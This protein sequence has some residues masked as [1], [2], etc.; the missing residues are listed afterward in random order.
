MPSH[1]SLET[2]N[3]LKK[4]K[5]ILG[6]RLEEFKTIK[7][8]I[9]I[10]L[11]GGLS[12]GYSDKYSEIDVLIYLEGQ[13]YR[14]YQNI[15]T[16]FEVGISMDH[17]Q[18]YDVS[19]VSYED[20]QEKEWDSL[21]CWDR[22]YAQIL[23]EKDDKITKLYQEKLTKEPPLNDLSSLMFHAHWS[24]QITG[25]VWIH[26]KD[27]MQG[28]LIFN[29]AIIPLLKC[30]FIINGEHIPHEK[31]IMHLSKTLDKLPDDYEKRLNDAMMVKDDTLESLMRR[32]KHLKA[33]YLEVNK[34]IQ[35]AQPVPSP[36]DVTHQYHQS[37]LDYLIKHQPC[38][39]QDFLDKFD[40]SILNTAPFFP[41]VTI[42]EE[43]I[44][45]DI[46]KLIS[47]KPSDMY[48]WHYK[49]IEYAKKLQ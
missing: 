23:Y 48:T 1:V 43:T 16:P 22:G 2:K 11:N 36:L 24:M 20:E 17:G 6:N 13:Y 42:K 30:L 7:G 44:H 5:K 19:L 37:V 15:K 33:L 9:G 25:D 29:Q 46:N 32:Q 26:R 18:L 3:D 38:P 28:H 40:I 21:M 45:L 31:W 4:H 35:Q 47:L 8:L 12:R 14:Y 49:L 39:K 41:C 27:V 10:V 34:L